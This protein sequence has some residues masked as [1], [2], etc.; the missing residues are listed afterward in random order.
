MNQAQLINHLLWLHWPT[1]FQTM[2]FF[3]Q[4]KFLHL[5][6][7]TVT[8][9]VARCGSQTPRWL[10]VVLTSLIFPSH[11]VSHWFIW[12]IEYSKSEDVWLLRSGHTRHCCFCLFRSWTAC[13]RGSPHVVS[14]LRKPMERPMWKG[15]AAS[16]P[17]PREVNPPA[18]V[19]PLGGCSPAD[20]L[21]ATS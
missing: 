16:C 3:V 9:P 19:M 5:I 18:P 14:T 12:P 10:P 6:L 1:L 7:I 13:S 4:H 17:E 15:T 11:T 21:T 2:L 8:H 20:I